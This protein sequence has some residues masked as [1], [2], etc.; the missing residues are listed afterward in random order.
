MIKIFL[1]STFREMAYE[2]D[3]IAKTV[4]P[5]ARK[6]AKEYK[7]YIEIC[8]LRWG[9]DSDS[10]INT[11]KCCLKKID[12]ETD[13][14]I[15]IIGND[16]GT[17][18][19]IT[20][21]LRELLKTFEIDSYVEA[22]DISIT[23]LEL[24]YG[25]FC[26]SNPIGRCYYKEGAEKG[27]NSDLLIR[28][29]EKLGEENC[30]VFSDIETI[31]CDL[32]KYIRALIEQ[33]KA[34]QKNQNWI[35]EELLASKS[36]VKDILREA[37][38]G[39]SGREELRENLL[40]D[41]NKRENS[42]ICLHGK[43]GF[44]KST[45]LADAYKK[46]SE[47]DNNYFVACGYGDKSKTYL[48]LLQQL[49]YIVNGC[50]AV[51]SEEEIWDVHTVGAAERKLEQLILE[52]NDSEN[53]PDTR[54]FIDGIDKLNMQ[55][56]QK[57]SLL[58]ILAQAKRMTSVISCIEEINVNASNI[59]KYQIEEL[60][61]RDIEQILR[62]TM[63]HAEV[64]FDSK[65][66]DVIKKKPGAVSPLYLIGAVTLM[67]MNVF[68]AQ[69]SDYYEYYE[70]LIDE[71]PDT[72]EGICHHVLNAAG[73]HLGWDE[74]ERFLQLLAASCNGISKNDFADLFAY[75]KWSWKDDDFYI[76]T[77]YL[78]HY[79]RYL[80]DGRINFSH[81][82]IVFEEKKFHQS[83]LRK[84]R[85]KWL[86]PYLQTNITADA[87]HIED[88]LFISNNECCADYALKL[89]AEI[90][91]TIEKTD[92]ED[93]EVM[94]LLMNNLKKLLGEHEWLVS[95]IAESKPEAML[96]ILHSGVRM[97]F[98]EDFERRGPAR[99]VSE[100][101]LQN[102]MALRKGCIGN[103]DED[104]EDL[105]RYI[106]QQCDDD[107]KK[108]YALFLAEY[109]GAC[110]SLSVGEKAFA[111]EDIALDILIGNTERKATHD[112]LFK[113]INCVFYSNN[114]LLKKS[115]D[116]KIPKEYSEFITK[117]AVESV[118]NKAITW[119]EDHGEQV[120]DVVTKGKFVNNIAQYHNALN[121]Y[122]KC[123][124]YRLKALNIKYH[125]LCV[126]CA[127][128][129]KD[130]KIEA[131]ALEEKHASS[132]IEFWEKWFALVWHQVKNNKDV[133]SV[134]LDVAISYRTFATDIYYLA[135]MKDVDS[136]A[137]LQDGIRFSELS[138]Y[139]QTFINNGREREMVVTRIRF[140][141]QLIK[142]YKLLIG[143]GLL[144]TTP[145]CQ[146]V[147]E[148]IYNLVEETRQG[149]LRYLK[150]DH[151]EKKKFNDNLLSCIEN[152][153]DLKK[154]LL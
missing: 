35:E 99:E 146:A 69:R 83:R 115:V 118:S 58:C 131:K 25:I 85:T 139:I 76:Y 153:L 141:G 27:K 111:Y 133:H 46:F 19:P 2:R 77:N 120:T 54:V 23:Q 45:I 6:L 91:P 1:S 59:K 52:Y 80:P 98:K 122:D 95:Y 22:N 34:Q 114:K 43:S 143:N 24:E 18:V 93:S 73:K 84:I 136:I 61:E 127:E 129:L 56:T 39:V 11:I 9:I 74:Y 134:L 71:M 13:S 41:L 31:V 101:F 154:H 126:W 110:E 109:I 104:R 147:T 14:V 62:S 97:H 21:E 50:T 112:E 28:L 148:K 66:V 37:E 5:F 79:F 102:H 7:E 132:H 82:I 142:L 33:K 105:R 72:V 26:K 57:I 86:F 89:F 42:I 130:K 3:E 137:V 64:R 125:I 53:A 88:G 63:V 124:P 108:R 12:P 16:I 55:E 119:F 149:F 90:E 135:D 36:L 68:A 152:G 49:I 128:I 78:D 107:T 20:D 94:Y 67:K 4:V 32:R 81:D 106:A 117:D 113:C 60:T 75:H 70:K 151:S 65:I 103:P 92:A 15:A 116:K 87:L 51:H 144:S 10:I 96:K 8:D 140:L 29:K 121:Q 145:E 30:I 47:T 100:V 38:K 150:H 17:T 40:S 138:I 48:N 44:G 123:R